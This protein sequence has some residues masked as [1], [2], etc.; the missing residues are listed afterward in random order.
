VVDMARGE[1]PPAAIEAVAM[2]DVHQPVGQPHQAAAVGTDAPNPSA[3][4]CPQSRRVE[5]ARMS[6][7]FRRS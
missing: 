7:P 5:L 6:I 3:S 2:S 4:S 1:R